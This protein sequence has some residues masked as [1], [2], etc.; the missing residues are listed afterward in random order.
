MTTAS[1]G[2]ELTGVGPGTAMGELMR[3]YWIPAG[4][5][6][7]LERDGAPIRLKLLGEK[8]IAFRD[9][10]G[11][12]G[13]MDHR[14]PHRCA[15]LFLGR[16]EERGIRCIYHGWKF[17]VA[18]NCVDMPSVPPH[19]DFKHKVKAKAYQVVE[20]GGVFWVYM[21]SRAAAPPTP[22]LEILDVP[23]DELRVMLIQRDC[24][25]LQAVEGEIDTSHFG[26]LHAGHVDPEDLAEDDPLRHTVINRA[27]QYHIA[28][29]AWGTHTTPATAQ[30]ARASPIG[31]S[32]TSC[33]RSGPKRRTASLA[34]TCTRAAGCPSTT[35]TRCSATCG[36]IAAPR[37]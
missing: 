13:V 21:G 26:F 12:V 35:A 18:G 15:S 6:S 28:D 37:R 19:Q 30:P 2:M 36:G 20:R 14:C 3:C 24:N 5:S 17:D 23:E 16:N 7:E 31:G 4:L 11:R 1:E 32:P 29:T 34:A 33:F 22:T 8:L 10:A 27:P 25:F 9:S